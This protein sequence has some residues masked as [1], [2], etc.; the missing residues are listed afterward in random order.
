MQ[1][2]H[3]SQLSDDQDPSLGREDSLVTLQYYLRDFEVKA[4]YRRLNL[5]TNMTVGE[6]RGG[7]WTAL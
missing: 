7:L 2:C 6:A 5:S 3:T 1:W 4:F